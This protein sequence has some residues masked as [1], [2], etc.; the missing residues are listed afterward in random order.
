[1]EFYTAKK[2]SELTGYSDKKCYK[3][4]AQ[5]NEELKKQYPNQIIFPAKIPIWYWKERTQP[6][7]LENK[8]ENEIWKK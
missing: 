2:L 5:M 4:I 6:I 1:M 7:K 8:E 3:I